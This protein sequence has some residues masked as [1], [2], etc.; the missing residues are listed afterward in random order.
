MSDYISSEELSYYEPHRVM[1]TLKKCHGRITRF[2]GT[3]T[4][5]KKLAVVQFRNNSGALLPHA[6]A[7]DEDLRM[8][9]TNED[10][11]KVFVGD[12]AADWSEVALVTE[13][14]VDFDM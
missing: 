13:G 14:P 6:P 4:F 3:D 5:L 12:L 7:C 1:T 8:L 9:R 11:T 10:D 2:D